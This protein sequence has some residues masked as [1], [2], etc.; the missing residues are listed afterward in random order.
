M[1]TT[2]PVLHGTRG[3][4]GVDGDAAG[5][6]SKCSH[7]EYSH[8]VHGDHGEERQGRVRSGLRDDGGGGGLPAARLIP[9]P[10]VQAIAVP[11]N[12]R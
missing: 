1:V 11:C 8:Y 7:D 5:G 4:D 10:T 2:M 9:A 3:G 12:S 6:E